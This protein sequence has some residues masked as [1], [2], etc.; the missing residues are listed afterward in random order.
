MSLAC[1]LGNGEL[2]VWGREDLE[3]VKDKSTHFPVMAGG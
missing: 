1:L 2:T 3:I